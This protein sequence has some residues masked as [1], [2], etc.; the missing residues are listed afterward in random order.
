MDR[1][2]YELRLT[3]RDGRSMRHEPRPVTETFDIDRE[4]DQFVGKHLVWMAAAAEGEDVRPHQKVSE[5]AEW[6]PQYQIEVWRT[7]G[8][9]KEPEVV[10][11]STH[12][13]K[14]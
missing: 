13:W 8:Y 9:W 12:G 5:F 1:R 10:S 14:D 11:T 6:L 3:R 2:K 4:L 7:D